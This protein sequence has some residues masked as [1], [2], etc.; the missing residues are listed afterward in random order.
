MNEWILMGSEIY[1]TVLPPRGV[2]I[3]IP[4]RHDRLCSSTLVVDCV[5]VA[6]C[7]LV[8]NVAEKFARG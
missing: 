7:I 1:R 5:E 3:P 2:P 4:T 8:C 6:G